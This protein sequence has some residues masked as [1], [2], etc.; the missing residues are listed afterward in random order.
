MPIALTRAV[1]PEIVNCELTHLQ[2]E[3]IDYERAVQQHTAYEN[4]LRK[5]GYTVKQIS[6][7]PELPDGVFVED[8]AVVFP[9]LA[10]ITRP[11]AKSRRPE[12][13]SMAEALSQYRELS[14]IEY[15]GTL[16]GGDVMVAGKEV[17]FGLSQRTNKEA[18]GQFAEIVKPLGYRVTGVPVR[19]CLHLKTA[20]SYVDEGLLLINPEWVNADAFPGY[21]CETVHPGEPY[22]ANVIR[23]ENRALCPVAFP[24]TAEWLAARGYDVLTIDQSELAKAEAG[25]TCCSILVG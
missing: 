15:P 10:V 24:H 21:R 19:N 9:E 23:R 8:T 7:T 3:P 18:I 17:F 11:G 12:T 20:A 2:R 1:S 16:D 22:G 6:E 14:F 25:V 4:A 13:E 5:I